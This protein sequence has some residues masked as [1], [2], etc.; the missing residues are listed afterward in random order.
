MYLMIYI[1]NYGTIVGPATRL[2]SVLCIADV[3]FN[4]NSKSMYIYIYIYI[5]IYFF[6]CNTEKDFLLQESVDTY[7]NQGWSIM[8]ADSTC[9]PS[10]HVYSCHNM[11]TCV[12]KITV[13][14]CITP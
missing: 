3:F 11:D 9:Y 6:F 13:L 7:Y 5:Y 8:I 12:K 1:H 10:T 4:Y 14:S 2:I